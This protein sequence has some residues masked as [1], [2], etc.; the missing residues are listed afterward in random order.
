MTVD[1]LPRF[2]LAPLEGRDDAAWTRSVNG[3]WSP[4]QIVDHLA[5]AIGLSAIGWHQQL[6]K[7]AMTRRPRTM[8]Q[9]VGWFVIRQT[10]FFPPGRKAPERTVPAAAPERNATEQKLRDAVRDWLALREKLGGRKDLF[11]KHPVLGDMTW[12]EFGAFHVRHAQHHV[13]QIQAR[14]R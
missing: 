11:L 5:T 9:R 1:D 7:P 10:G 2:I 6:A 4:V 12:D 14:T 13:R 8:A 3:E